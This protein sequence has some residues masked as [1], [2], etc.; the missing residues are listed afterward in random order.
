MDY[1]ILNI[2]DE[3]KLKEKFVFDEIVKCIDNDQSFVFDAGAGAGKTYA[4]VQSLKHILVRYGEELKTHKQKA[5]FITFTNVAAKEIEERL[6]TTNLIDVSTIHKWVWNIISP[7]QKQ[8]VEFHLNKLKSEVVIIKTNLENEKWAERFIKLSDVEKEFLKNLLYEKKEIYYKYKSSGAEDFRAN[9]PYI[10]AQFPLILKNVGDFKKIADNI[11]KLGR[12]NIAIEKIVSE[13]SSFKKLKYDPKFNND[14]LASMMISHETLLEY[15]E[16]IVKSNNILKQIIF[17]QYPYILVDEYQDTD[18]RVISTLSLIESYSKKINHKCLI[19]Y[20]GDKKQNIYDTGV[21]GKFSQH[22]PGLV[23]IK[24]E[25]NRRSSNKIIEVANKIRNDDLQQETIYS[26][27]PSG[28]VSFYNMSIERTAF[29]ESHIK[30]WDITKQNKLHCFELTNERVAEFSGFS[31]IYNFFKKSPWY[32]TGKRYE[33]LRDHILSLD[34]TKLGIIQSLIFRILDFKNKII[35][36]HTMILG[37]IVFGKKSD[38][39]NVTTLRKLI[40]KLKNKTGD[41]LKMYIKNLF[42]SYKSGDVNYD[43]C[44]E[45]IIGENINSFEEFELFILDQLYLL[46]AEDSN[47]DEE[48]A[49]YKG[50]IDEFLKIDISIFNLWYKFIID[51]SDVDIVYHTYHGTKGREFENVII[52]MNSK[53][54]VDKLYFDR[55]LKVISEKNDDEE[56]KI[57]EARNLLYV[58]VTRAVKNLSVL[59]FDDLDENEDQVK[60]V[61]GEIKTFLV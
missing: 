59:Y 28:S 42:S 32:K 53:F 24:K 60:S 45:Y 29:I 5:L 10:N 12:Y 57:E 39:I 38:D 47:A 27:F 15:T 34:T 46:D 2:S 13:D 23:R 11:F 37:V 17:D 51:K 8:L 18:P 36:D 31:I 50:Q 56:Q 35:L 26:D 52:F 44:I 1:K 20:Y 6:G 49:E 30:L 33:F 48:L 3:N 7:H 19:G 43:K 58:A 4:L 41:T 21:G 9:F 54:G 61:F 22:H 40:M 16:K 14:R 55:L 25:F